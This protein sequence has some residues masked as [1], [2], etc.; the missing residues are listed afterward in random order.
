MMF[1]VQEKAPAG[2]WS[3]KMGTNHMEKVIDFAQW[4]T[5]QF[6]AETRVISRTDIQVWSS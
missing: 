1:W 3:D 4:L 5:K 6:K 2:N